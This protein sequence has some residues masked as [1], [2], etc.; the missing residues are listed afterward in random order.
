MNAVAW[1]N[2]IVGAGEE[3]PAELRANPRNWR[4][5]PPHQHAALGQ[6]LD[7]IGWVA[8]V[9]VN[10]TTGNLVDGHLR[11]ELAAARGE[12]VVP[13]T[14]VELTEEEEQLALA[15]LDPIGALAERDGDALADL[16]ADLEVDGDLEKMLAELAPPA[17]DGENGAGTAEYLEAMSVSLADPTH[18][19]EAGE[20]WRVGRSVLVVASI[21]DGWPLY[22]PLLTGERLLVPYPSPIVPLTERARRAELVMVQPDTWLAGHL[23][24]KFA[25]VY[26]EEEVGRAD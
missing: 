8:Q 7:R 4:R 12:P 6:A 16:I 15:T 23:L 26:G 3:S 18:T 5:H 24:D 19:V 25:E 9:T 20:V 11:V 21:Y 22:A 2:K 13:V 14:Y 17:P 1:A 10:R